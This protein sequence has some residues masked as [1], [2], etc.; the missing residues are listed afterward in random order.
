MR[1]RQLWVSALAIAGLAT[2][3]S[4]TPDSSE[5]LGESIVI[6]KYSPDA[7]FGAYKTFFIRPEVRMLSDDPDFND[8]DECK[9]GKSRC[10][11]SRYADALVETTVDE[12]TKR[13]YQEVDDPA[14]AEL[15]VELVYLRSVTTSVSCYSWWDP[16][17][18]GYPGWGYY[19]Y[20]GTCAASTWRS[21]TL[22]TNLIDLSEAQE[23]PDVGAG[24]AGGAGG[25]EVI[26]KLVSSVW[27]SGVYGIEYD[28]AADNVSR[29]RDGI[30]EAFSQSPY[31]DSK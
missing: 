20:Y 10:I 11:D 3:C 6:T 15:G 21:G 16:Y 25:G 28:Y 7:D 29:A 8:G 9:D 14:D 1:G 26:N 13:G 19:P 18:W 24:G 27:F 30:V 5:R 2:G 31:L 23:N 22:A 4:E 17:Y 12:L